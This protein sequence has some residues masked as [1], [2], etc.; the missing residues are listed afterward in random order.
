MTSASPSQARSSEP[1]RSVRA[2]AAE[3]DAHGLDH[4]PEIE[5]K[6]PIVDVLSLE[7][8]D[9]FEIRDEITPADLPR[10]RQPRHDAE[11]DE[12]PR[13][14]APNFDRNRRAWSHERHLAGEHIEELRQLVEAEST[15]QPPDPRDSR[16]VSQLEQ[17]AVGIRVEVSNRRALAFGLVRHAAKLPH[18]EVA[19]AKSDATLAKEDRAR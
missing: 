18:H 3:N 1:E 15:K 11:A 12:M 16:I 8:N 4:D 10:P 17:P 7:T 2:P 9:F 19:A 13:L 5:P 14:V 6:R